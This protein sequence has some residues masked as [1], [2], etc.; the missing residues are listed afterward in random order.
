MVSSGLLAL[1]S[2]ARPQAPTTGGTEKAVAVLEEQW[3]QSQKTNSTDLG[4]SRK[5]PRKLS[6]VTR[7]GAKSVGALSGAASAL[8]L[9]ENLNPRRSWS[10]VGAY[11]IE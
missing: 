10:I 2:A 4:V 7:A 3:L 8:A 11:S 6:S 5:H 1:G 9:N